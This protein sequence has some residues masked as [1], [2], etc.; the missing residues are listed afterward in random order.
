MLQSHSTESGTIDTT[1]LFTQKELTK[2]CKLSCVTHVSVVKGS[3]CVRPSYYISNET[4]SLEDT[5]NS[6]HTLPLAYTPLGG[7]GSI[8]LKLKGAKF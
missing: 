2:Y 5:A 6:L 4:V 8:L 1:M 7:G 3:Y